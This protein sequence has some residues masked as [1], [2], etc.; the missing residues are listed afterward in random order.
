MND[1]RSCGKSSCIAGNKHLPAAFLS[2][3]ESN[4]VNCHRKLLINLLASDIRVRSVGFVFFLSLY[5]ATERDSPG[6][7]LTLHRSDCEV[8][9]S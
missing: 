1:T 6:F 2:L 4:F 3:T 8:I 9:F 7:D 5:T